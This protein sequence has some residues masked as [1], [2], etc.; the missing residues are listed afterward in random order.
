M[1]TQALIVFTGR[2]FKGKTSVAAVGESEDWPQGKLKAGNWREKK[3]LRGAVS[4]MEKQSHSSLN[5]LK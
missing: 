4:K 2:S 3:E 5:L 1:A